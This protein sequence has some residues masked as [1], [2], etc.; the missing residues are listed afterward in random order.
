MYAQE[1]WRNTGDLIR[2][3]LQGPEPDAREGQAG[4]DEESE[5]PIVPSK[6]GNVGRGKG[7]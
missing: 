7:P 2:R 1:F 6:P 5:R 3:G 4:P